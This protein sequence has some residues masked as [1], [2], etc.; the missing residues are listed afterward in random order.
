MDYGWN[1]AEMPCLRSTVI[2]FWEYV[3]DRD[4]AKFLAG[5]V[6]VTKLR[7]CMCFASVRADVL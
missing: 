2:D 5:L 3:G 6:Q 1:F 4:F 7:I